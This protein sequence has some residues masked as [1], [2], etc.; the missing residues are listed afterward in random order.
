MNTH[1]V[2]FTLRSRNSKV[3]PIP[4]STT[5]RET[6]PDACPLRGAGCY[7]EGGPLGI[8]WAAL[9]RATPGAAIQMA[10]GVL[11]SLT[12]EGFCRAVSELP[13]GQL[14]R[15][16]QAGDLPGKGDHIDRRALSRVVKAN[17]GRRGFTYSHKPLTPANAAA[18]KAA[19]AAGLTINLSAN[20]LAHA[21]TLMASGVGPVVTVL[22]STVT[23]HQN[24]FT[25]AGHRVVPCPATY[26]DDT[27]C[28][29]C[30]LCAVRDRKCIVGFPAHGASRKR[31][32]TATQH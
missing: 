18:I 15:M 25:P 3:G 27:T 6:C 20:N 8:I 11:Q 24:I 10:R 2:L 31:A 13:N 14:W 5:S 21:D 29:S 1:A 30:R 32:E 23:S 7:A 9:S 16:N 4:V 17:R 19:N 28:D 22:P 12:W 26:R